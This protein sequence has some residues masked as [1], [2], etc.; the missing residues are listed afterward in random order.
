V[1]VNDVRE[2]AWE[3]G[4]KRTLDTLKTASNRVIFISDTP[5]STVSP[6]TCLASHKSSILACSTPIT[7]AVSLDW[8]GH[9]EDVAMNENVTWVDPTTWVCSSNPCSPIS[10]KILI[11]VDGGHLT[12][13]FARTLEKPL[14]KEISK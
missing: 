11:Y 5:L 6:P 4:M 12:A 7:S 10:G 13:T 9:E 8:L 14:W 3:A 1:L 2:M